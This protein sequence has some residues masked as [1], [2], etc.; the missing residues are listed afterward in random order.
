MLTDP[1][2]VWLVNVFVDAWVVLQTMDPVDA[3]IIEGHVKDCRD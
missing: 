2:V 1:F 3:D